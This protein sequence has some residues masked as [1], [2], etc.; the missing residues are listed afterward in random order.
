MLPVI[1]RNLLESIRLLASVS[2]LFAE[3]CVDGITADEERTRAF[4][5][6]SPSIVT[7]LNHYVGYDEAA[8]IAKQALAEH[9]TIRE[10]VIERGHVASGAITEETLDRVLDVLAM[11]RPSE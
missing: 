6:S 3:R 1:A 2:R 10:V 11:T 9:K 5:E 7:P 4:A 8:K